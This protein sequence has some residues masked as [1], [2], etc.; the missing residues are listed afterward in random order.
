[1][2]AAGAHPFGALGVTEHFSETFYVIA[3]RNFVL[4][5]VSNGRSGVF[6]PSWG[7]RYR[8]TPPAWQC[9]LTAPCRRSTPR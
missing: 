3:Q 2:W 8:S 4:S 7:C 6:T 5:Q 9:M 1:M